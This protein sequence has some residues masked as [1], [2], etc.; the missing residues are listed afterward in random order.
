MP[1]GQKQIVYKT[2][3]QTDPFA[4]AVESV[5]VK[6]RRNT[7]MVLC[8]DDS[9]PS[10]LKATVRSARANGTVVTVL[11]TP[12]V[13]FEADGLADAENAYES[14]HSFEKLRRDLNQL[15]GVSA[16]EV[17]PGDRLTAVLAAGG[18]TN[19]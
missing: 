6:P 15:D 13:L 4:T 8:T 12:T 5:I 2:R 11:L 10:K 3:I 9:N 19:D 7:H 17:G 16:L 14:Y 1:T 18:Q